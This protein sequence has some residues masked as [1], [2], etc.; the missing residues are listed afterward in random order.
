[1]FKS[2]KHEVIHLLWFKNIQLRNSQQN[3]NL[4]F[5]NPTKTHFFVCVSTN[6]DINKLNWRFNHIFLVIINRDFYCMLVLLINGCFNRRKLKNEMVGTMFRLGHTPFF[7]MGDF[8]PVSYCKK[9]FLV[10]WSCYII[11]TI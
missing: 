11:S 9:K 2:L 7:I 5:T 6:T 4:K 8:C 1:M 10:I 3:L